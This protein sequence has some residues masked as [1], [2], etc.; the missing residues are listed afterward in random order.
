MRETW[1]KTLYKY[2]NRVVEFSLQYF[3]KAGATAV[4]QTLQ[5]VFANFQLYGYNHL[6][7]EE[8]Y[9]KIDMFCEYV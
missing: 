2:A 1:R 6:E 4:E 9:V 8:D 7:D 5:E 3:G